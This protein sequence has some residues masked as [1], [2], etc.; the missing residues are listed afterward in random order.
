MEL[1]AWFQRSCQHRRPSPELIPVMFFLYRPGRFHC[2]P[3][4]IS[5]VALIVPL[6][7]VI[8]DRA[9][10]PQFLTALMVANANAGNLSPVSSV[11]VIASTQKWPRPES[12][13]MSGKCGFKF[14]CTRRRFCRCLPCFDSQG[15]VFR[16]KSTSISNMDHFK[17]APDNGR[18][19]S[20]L[21]GWSRWLSP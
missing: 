2:R 14:R 16:P 21:D 5:A 9:G 11:G 18:R 10:I 20:P 13:D 17:G 6:A 19:D 8:S 4:A 15:L 7:M 3:G 12:S 1:S